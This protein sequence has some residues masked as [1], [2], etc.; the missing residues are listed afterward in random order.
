MTGRVGIRNGGKMF[1]FQVDE[2]VKLVL[3]QP[4]MAGEL[5]AVVL[6][7]LDRLKPWMPWATKDYS[8]DLANEFI[9]RSLRA[10]ADEGRFEAVIMFGNEIIGSIGFHNLDGTNRSAHVGYWIAGKYEGKGFV[11]RCCRA[12]IDYLFDTMDLNRVQINC[13]V[14]NLRSRAIPERL[15]FKLEG[16][17]R[18]VEFL[19]D[20]FGDWAVYALLRE[21]W[22]AQN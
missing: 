3:P 9:A 12:V 8:A 18:Q 20:R 5:T 16:I 15:G 19:H 14:E 4:H 22:K 17:H 6:E 10:F 7:N 13:N 21:E 2:N 11:T 1:S